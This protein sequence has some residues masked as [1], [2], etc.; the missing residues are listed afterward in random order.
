MRIEDYKSVQEFIY[1]YNSGLVKPSQALANEKKQLDNKQQ[2]K[3][4]SFSEILNR[5]VN[6]SKKR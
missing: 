3:K 2:E 5:E 4:N 6:K 1:R